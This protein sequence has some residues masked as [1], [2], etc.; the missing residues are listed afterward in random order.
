MT[1]ADVDPTWLLVL[2]TVTLVAITGY[3]AKQTRDLSRNQ[4][5]PYCY[6]LLQPNTSLGLS[7]HIRNNGPGLACNVKVEYSIRGVKGSTE[8]K[9]FEVIEMN[10][11]FPTSFPLIQKTAEGNSLPLKHDETTERIIDVEVT[12]SDI[13]G[14]KRTN[15]QYFTEN[16]LF[17]S[18][19]NER[20]SEKEKKSGAPFG[21]SK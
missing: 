1:L 10:S 19:S 15:T 9:S 3:Y 13:L 5:R 11:K 14:K 4:F 20:P 21:V 12:F 17:T 16:N 18:F 2:S 6:A 8:S 7:L